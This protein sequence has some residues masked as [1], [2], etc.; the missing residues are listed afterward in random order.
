M[1]GTTMLQIPTEHGYASK[2]GTPPLVLG[3]FFVEVFP[4]L[5]THLET[6]PHYAVV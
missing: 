2:W 1:L 5:E 4:I 6:G 3:M